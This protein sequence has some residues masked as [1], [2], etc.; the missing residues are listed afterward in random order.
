MK[1]GKEI[2]K[3]K[4]GRTGKRERRKTEQEIRKGKTKTRRRTGKKERRERGR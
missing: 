3:R 4:I 2:R 1:T